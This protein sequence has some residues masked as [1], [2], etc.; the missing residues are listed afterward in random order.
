MEEE[1][2]ISSVTLIFGESSLVMVCSILD[3]YIYM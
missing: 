3:R 2:I 1:V